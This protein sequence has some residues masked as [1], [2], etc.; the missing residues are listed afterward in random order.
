[1]T[2]QEHVKYHSLFVSYDSNHDGFLSKDEA[3]PIYQKS[4][5]DMARVEMI[6]AMVDEDRDGLLTPKEFCAAFHIIVCVT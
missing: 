2:P 4:G 1:M 6:Y 5:M 3:L